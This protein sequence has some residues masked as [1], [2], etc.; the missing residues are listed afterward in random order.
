[1]RSVSAAFD[2]ILRANNEEASLKAYHQL[3]YAVGNNH[4][5]TYYSVALGILP[6]V[7]SV[8]LDGSP[9]AKQA[10]LEVLIELCGPFRPESGQELYQGVSLEVLIKE[11]VAS[12]APIVGTLAKGEEVAAKS[13]Q[14]LLGVMDEL[15]T[16]RATPTGTTDIPL[17]C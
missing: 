16:E 12:L 1:M 5:G 17:S 14:E 13:A 11:R 3:L 15:R 8:L 4:A 2:V 7:E 6:A 10:V 9:W